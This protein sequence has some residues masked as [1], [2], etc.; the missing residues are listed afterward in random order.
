MIRRAL[1]AGAALG[2]SLTAAGAA[3]KLTLQLDAP[4]LRYGEPEPAPQRPLL[5]VTQAGI[6][7]LEGAR[8]ALAAGAHEEGRDAA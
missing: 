5:H 1:I 7:G 2:L 6:D 8:P 4:L 3:E